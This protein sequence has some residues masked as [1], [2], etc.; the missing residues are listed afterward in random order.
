M[1]DVTGKWLLQDHGVAHHRS[2]VLPELQK[3]L[4][5]TEKRPQQPQ[6]LVTFPSRGFRAYPG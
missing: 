6:Q 2:Q 4:D 3:R 5:P 1:N